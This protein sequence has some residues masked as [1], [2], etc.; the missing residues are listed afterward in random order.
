MPRTFY[1]QEPPVDLKRHIREIPDFP[2][3]GTLFYDLATLFL[4]A[5]AFREAVTRLA[6][7]AARHK[8]QVIAGIESRGFPV[9]APIAIELGLGLLMIRKP[10]KLPGKVLRHGYRK[11]YGRDEL[12]I[13]ADVGL[14]G[15]RVVIVDDLL[16]TGG[17]FVAATELLRAAGALVPC[18]LFIVEL[19]ALGG[20][21]KSPVP[22]ETLLRY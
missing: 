10:G 18:G 17:T 2:K 11:E 21:E 14:A 1:R 5:E 12:E 6:A 3:P 22:V 20:R 7:A 8:P 16:A 19:A 15:Q 9:A 4:N 13:P